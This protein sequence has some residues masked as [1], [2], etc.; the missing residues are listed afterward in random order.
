MA[1]GAVVAQAEMKNEDGFGTKNYRTYVLLVLMTVYTVNFIDRT[2]IAVVA[3]PIIES[4]DLSDTQ[5]GLLYGPPFALFYAVMGLP[6]AMWADRSNRIRIMTVC[7]ILWSIMTALCGVAAG[8]LMLL[9]FRI[10]VA[11]GEAG[12]TPPANSIIGD[13]FQPK[14][15]ATA[16]GIY[17]MGVTLGGVLAN[18][19][20]GPIASM[21]GV[22]FGNWLSSIGLGW[23]FSG[24]DWTHIEG[25]RIAFVVVGLPGVLIALLVYLTVREPPRGFSD[26]EPKVKEEAANLRDTLTELAGKPTFLWMTIGASFVAFVGYG[27]TS[28]QAPFL[29]REHGIDVR[30]AA[31]NYGAPLAAMSA[32]GTFLGGWLT[33]KMTPY[34]KTAVA[35]IPAVGLLIAVPFYI[36]AFY[37][38]NLT[39]VFI[40]WA[41]AATTHYAYLGAQ[42]NIGQ[43]VVS[44]RSR[45]TAIAILL[46]MVSIIGNGVGPY[47][48]GFF[49]DLFMNMQL[50]ADSGLSVKVCTG[51]DTLTGEQ[52]ALCEMASSTGLKQ[53]ISL[54]VCW[55]IFAAGCFLMSAKT[56]ERDFV[57]KLETA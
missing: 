26:P 21:T 24:I 50:P 54:T 52:M 20:G 2:L 7:I 33:E 55:F 49:S 45:A 3:Q 17:S 46:I 56:L 36:A 14:S 13:Y 41:I 34:S 53:A 32:L 28:F 8:F 10:G 42:Y 16:L 47:F 22:E 29:Q 23:F 39:L 25:W 1:N 57:A 15:R 4:F 11:I 48:V 19:F 51:D 38:S 12:C 37:A 6:I 18:L 5:W 30:E 27:L 9:F 35:W 40:F 44:N 43:S 31:V